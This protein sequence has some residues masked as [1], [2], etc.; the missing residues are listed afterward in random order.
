MMIFFKKL[1]DKLDLIMKQNALFEQ[2]ILCN[3]AKIQDLLVNFDE[4]KSFEDSLCRIHDKLNELLADENRKEQVK[5]SEKTLDKFENYMKNVDTLNLLINEFKGCV[6]MAR[7]S[8]SINKE[9]K[10]PLEK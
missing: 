6:S 3:L 10:K 2:K 7:A 5:L 4:I 1:H 8:L 9:T